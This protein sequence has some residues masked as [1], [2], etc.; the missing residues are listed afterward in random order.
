MAL[1]L[2]CFLQLKVIPTSPSTL[3]ALSSQ[4]AEPSRPGGSRTPKRPPMTTCTPPVR[5]TLAAFH[6]QSPIQQFQRRPSRP[7][8]VVDPSNRGEAQH[9][10]ICICPRKAH[11]HIPVLRPSVGTASALPQ[12]GFS[13][14]LCLLANHEF[15]P[16]MATLSKGLTQCHAGCLHVTAWQEC[17]C[18]LRQLSSRI[19]PSSKA[20]ASFGV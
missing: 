14:H 11:S 1:V 13:R 17:N 5:V 19:V 12:R 10:Q 16:E 3:R 8:A 9:Q 2:V 15:I 4:P 20:W 18:A 6:P 7:I